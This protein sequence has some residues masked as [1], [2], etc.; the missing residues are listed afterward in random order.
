MNFLD[1]LERIL[2]TKDDP[3]PSEADVVIGFDFGFAENGISASPQS[4]AVAEKC[5]QIFQTG[6]AKKVILSGGMKGLS[7]ITSAEAMAE[8]ICQRMPPENLFV[9]SKSLRTYGNACCSLE[10]MQKYNWQTA[11]VV[12]Q[13]WHAR[14]VKATLKKTWAGRGV[15]FSVVKARSSYGDNFS[16]WHVADNFLF[17]CIYDTLAF[18]Y[19][20]LKKYC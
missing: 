11:I 1:W 17:F 9:E 3:L 5:L 8:V 20:K 12:A 13:Q 19:F 14:R 7:G 15:S 2:E 18:A 16:P 4:A 6:I 10:I